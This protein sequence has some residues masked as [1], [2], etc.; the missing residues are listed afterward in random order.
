MRPFKDIEK[1][2]ADR[3]GGPKALAKLLPPVASAKQ[4]AGIGD[5]RWLSAMAK[6]VFQAGFSWKVVENKWP[7]FEAAFHGFDP[8]RCAMMPDEEI[9]ALL[10]NPDVIR[11]GAKLRS[12]R[13]NAVF[14]TDLARE[15]GSAAMFFAAWPDD[16][17]VGL[18]DLLKKRGSR[19]GGATGMFL[20]RGM[21]KD[22]FITSG[23]MVTALIREGV[24]DKRPSGKRDMA[25]VQAACNQWHEESGRPLTHIS[26]I[27]AMSV[28][29]GPMPGHYVGLN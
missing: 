2:A 6:R 9:E 12:V 27:L 10:K 7:G 16:D 29:S 22:S 20:L 25:K 21:G 13:E 11:N 19:L 17:Y 1:L 28:D 8:N 15:H 3:K 24:V 4:L 26:R 23:D 5:D 14:V 18:L